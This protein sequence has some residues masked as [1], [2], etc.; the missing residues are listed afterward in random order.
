MAH[1]WRSEDNLWK[2]ILFYHVGPWDQ[3][4]AFR[5][6]NKCLWPWSHLTEPHKFSFLRDSNQAFSDSEFLRE[7]VGTRK[8]L[9]TRVTSKPYCCTG[10]GRSIARALSLVSSRL[11]WATE[12]EPVSKIRNKGKRKLSC[13]VLCVLCLARLVFNQ[14]WPTRSWSLR[15]SCLCANFFH[16]SP[17]FLCPDLKMTSF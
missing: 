4:H 10:G 15:F 2:A 1:V 7:A 11:A 16:P 9:Q 14:F 12:W 8:G 13:D 17:Q 3:I 5:L 6:E